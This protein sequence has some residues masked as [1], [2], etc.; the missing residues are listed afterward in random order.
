MNKWNTVLSATALLIGGHAQAAAWEPLPSDEKLRLNIAVKK[1]AG[2]KML[3]V[4]PGDLATLPRIGGAQV[5]PTGETRAKGAMEAGAPEEVIWYASDAQSPP[6]LK[7]TEA[8]PCLIAADAKLS[9]RADAWEQAYDCLRAIA[10][11][12]T[13]AGQ[14]YA[15]KL[16]GAHPGV[17]VLAVEPVLDLVVTKKDKWQFTADQNAA[18]PVLP[19]SPVWPSGAPGWHLSADY[20]Q[21]SPAYRKV[22]GESM[23]RQGSI[24]V[25]HLD[26][27]YTPGD[28]ML[29]R[30]HD[31]ALSKTCQRDEQGAIS[32]RPG[33]QAHWDSNVLLASPGHGAATLSNLAGGYYDNGQGQTQMGG[34]P[35]AHVY[36]INI[37]DTFVHLDSRQMAAGIEAAVHDQADLITLSHGGFP[38]MRLAY[39][40]DLAYTSGTPIFAASGDFLEFPLFLGRTFR[41]VV[42]P[43]RYSQVM[44]VA[45]VTMKEGSYGDNPNLLWWFSF[46]PGYLSRLGSWMLRGNYGPASVM[47][48]ANFISA[49]V[50]NITRSDPAS[51]KDYKIA[52]NGGGTSHATPQVAAA[53]SLWLEGHKES[54]LKD[55]WRSW[56][57]SEA[58]YQALT[59][60]AKKC[61]ADYNVEHYGQGILRAGDA[62]DWKYVSAQT[63]TGSISKTDSS[64]TVPLIKKEAASLDLPGVVEALRSIRLPGQFEE[65]AIE[66]FHNALITELAQVI[67]TSDDLQSFLQKFHLCKP[68]EGCERCTRQELSA[69][70]LTHL[71]DLIGEIP[72]AS[73]TLKT[74][75]RTLW[76]AK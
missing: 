36:S 46:G 52:S 5:P 1:T 15:R 73:Q 62:L 21:L 42:Y 4:E 31:R 7:S 55:K 30:H 65:T 47:S 3:G 71:A 67:F 9:S 33:G 76:G 32:C 26:T 37:H 14:P 68:A 6:R 58:V 74:T 20:S 25:A 11:G 34:N 70:D 16:L 27:G 50:P 53:A 19:P 22:F 17:K 39:A 66:A 44:G 24:L 38:S 60:S 18:T 40:V 10:S 63:G 35:S 13:A 61:F 69:L 23:D 48:E 54:P 45:G 41:S 59:Q 29:P 51:D 64:K 43:A 72:D 49:Y 12:T 28:P 75:L 56:E 8:Q 2:V 57:K